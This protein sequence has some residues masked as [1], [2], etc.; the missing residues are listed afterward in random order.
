MTNSHEAF[1]LPSSTTVCLLCK[2]TDWMSHRDEGL[3]AEQKME[4]RKREIGWKQSLSKLCFHSRD[5]DGSGLCLKTLLSWLA[6]EGHFFPCKWEIVLSLP[7]SLKLHSPSHFFTPDS[8]NHELFLQMVTSNLFPFWLKNWICG[9][10]IKGSGKEQDKLKFPH[11]PFHMRLNTKYHKGTVFVKETILSSNL[12]K[13]RCACSCLM[14]NS[15]CFWKITVN[16][17]YPE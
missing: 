17:H 1:T 12:Y 10:L 13:S 2:H 3:L 9:S 11:E 6:E 4:K 5:L 15:D 14:E 7:P 8:L 16:F